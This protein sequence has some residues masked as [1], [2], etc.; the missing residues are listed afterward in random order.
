MPKVPRFPR[1]LSA[2]RV[3]LAAVGVL[4]IAGVA[5][6]LRPEAVGVETALVRRAPLRVTVDAEGKTRVRDRY[7][8]A[9]PV[10]GRA[11][12]AGSKM[13]VTSGARGDGRGTGSRN[14]RNRIT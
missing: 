14:A 12:R 4:A 5:A 13:T 7:V 2:K 1:V 11:G 9:A 6:A 3:A 8:I 10:S